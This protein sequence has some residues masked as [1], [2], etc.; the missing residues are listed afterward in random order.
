MSTRAHA[1]AVLPHKLARQGAGWR[2]RI[3]LDRFARFNAIVQPLGEPVEVELH[4]RLDDEGRCRVEGRART[5][6]GIECGRCLLP[7]ARQLDVP[8]DLVLVSSDEEASAIVSTSD[9]F[10]LDG[11]EVQVVDLLEDDLILALPVEVCEDVATCPNRPSYDYPP[12]SEE[13]NAARPSP[14]A[15]LADLVGKRG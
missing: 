11:E 3:A 6:V 1:D 13:E 10:V 14:F 5:R 15:G 7:Q 4:F 9:P 8:V 2:G 12:A